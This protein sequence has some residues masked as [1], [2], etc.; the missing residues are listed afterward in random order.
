[1]LMA[2]CTTAPPCD[3]EAAKPKPK[4]KPKPTAMDIGV[5]VNVDVDVDV[6]TGKACPGLKA[7]VPVA[8]EFTVWVSGRIGASFSSKVRYGTSG[9]R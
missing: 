1:M 3:D 6:E 5:D 4:P 7:S 8:S 9:S 2:D